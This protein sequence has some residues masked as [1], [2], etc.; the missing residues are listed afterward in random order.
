MAKSSKKAPSGLRPRRRG[1]RA[2]PRAAFNPS[3]RRDWLKD[4]EDK[5]D[6]NHEGFEL[7]AEA[8]RNK[9]SQE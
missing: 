4:L 3:N 5:H 2:G 9:A 7:P 1:R 6:D 8:E